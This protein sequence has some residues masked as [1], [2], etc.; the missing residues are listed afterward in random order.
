VDGLDLAGSSD[1]MSFYSAATG[2]SDFVS[3]RELQLRETICTSMESM[4]DDEQRIVNP[5]VASEK[6]SFETIIP[7]P[8]KEHSSDFLAETLATENS[9]AKEDTTNASTTSSDATI[10]DDSQRRGIEITHDLCLSRKSATIFGMGTIPEPSGSHIGKGV[11]LVAQTTA[12]VYIYARIPQIAEMRL[13]FHATLLD[14]KR[15]PPG[16]GSGSLELTA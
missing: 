1:Q 5:N 6:I 8:P 11:A 7:R 12:F 2:A 14:V 13:S 4:L 16:L 10:D 9:T 15:W 3:Q